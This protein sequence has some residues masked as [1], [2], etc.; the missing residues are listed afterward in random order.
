MWKFVFL[1]ALVIGSSSMEI[2]SSHSMNLKNFTVGFLAGV[3]NSTSTCSTSMGNVINILYKITGDI[4]LDIKSPTLQETINTL[5]DLQI[6]VNNIPS[7]R[8]CDFSALNDALMSLF[9]LNGLDQLVQN[10]LNNG[11]QIFNDYNTILKCNANYFNCGFSSGTAFR[12][13]SGWTLN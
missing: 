12:L 8:K 2:E 6:F 10:Y 9:T 3:G 5:N 4:S 7:V 11:E 1:A 13:L